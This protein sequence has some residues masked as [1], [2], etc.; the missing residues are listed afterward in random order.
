M[1]NK[2]SKMKILPKIKLKRNNALIKKIFGKKNK[3][4][5]LEK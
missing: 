1:K 3:K 5:A 2:K 4:I